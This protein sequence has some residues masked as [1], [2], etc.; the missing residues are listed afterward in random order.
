MKL[1][2][3]KSADDFGWQKAVEA[4]TAELSELFGEKVS[5]TGGY[6]FHL[7]LALFL[8]QKDRNIEIIGDNG[9]VAIYDRDNEVSVDANGVHRFED[10][11][12][13]PARRRWTNPKAFM[14]AVSKGWASEQQLQRL[15]D[16][17]TKFVT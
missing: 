15:Q 10:A 17:Y 12:N 4:T 13:E 8:Q 6:C 14:K 7:A 2:E 9:H 5:F 3:L 1:N 11:L 16:T